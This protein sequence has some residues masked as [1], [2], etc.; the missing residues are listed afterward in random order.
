MEKIQ[1]DVVTHLI[2]AFAIPTKEGTLLPL[3]NSYAAQS[4]IEAAHQQGNQLL[5]GVGG[6]SYQGNTLQSVFEQATATDEKL[7]RLGD[8]I[9]TMCD[10]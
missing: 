5:L 2:Y 8:A 6:W 3:E 9:L 1:H 7:Y 4:L 10:Q